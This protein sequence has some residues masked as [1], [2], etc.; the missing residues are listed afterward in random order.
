MSAA[1]LTIR[2]AWRS[3]WS[4]ATT[5]QL[6]ALEPA[7][8]EIRAEWADTR[9]AYG[10][11]R[12][13]APIL[14]D[15]NPKLQRGELPAVGLTLSPANSAEFGT[16]CSMSTAECERDCLHYAGRAAFS[17][18]IPAARAART[19]FIAT[20]PTGAAY[21]VRNELRRRLARLPALGFRANVLSDLMPGPW[22]ADELREHAGRLVAW[23][24]T[25]RPDAMKRADGV[26]R[27]FSVSERQRTP[28]DVL[29][30]LERGHRVAIVAPVAKTWT[31]PA[32]SL[33]RD[34][35][36]ND[37]RFRDPRPAVVVLRPKGRLRNATPA[38]AGFVK[39]VEWLDE[40]KHL[41]AT[42]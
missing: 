35:D 38:P 26:D 11:C 5:E 31:P 12:R 37:E 17:A 15:G 1:K 29:E 30:I 14:S 40:L 19:A 10:F 22:L 32:G 27:T 7:A 20:N 25:K 2:R 36:T 34:G 3:Q 33:L 6:D 28:A 42:A 39:P 23:D 18:M 8:K 16:V 21:L 4:R 13:P 41:G 9:H 24:Y